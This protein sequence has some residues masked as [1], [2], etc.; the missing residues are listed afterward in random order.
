MIMYLPQEMKR[1]CP[2]TILQ[3]LIIQEALIQTPKTKQAVQDA[4]LY[5]SFRT[6]LIFIGPHRLQNQTAGRHLC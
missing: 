3:G 6:K 4:A 1:G 5:C 2:L